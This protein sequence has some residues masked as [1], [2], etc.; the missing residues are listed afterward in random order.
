MQSEIVHN[1]ELHQI[2]N[3]STGQRLRILKSAADTKRSIAS[4]G[5]HLPA[6]FTGTTFPLPPSSAGRISGI[7]GR[8][9]RAYR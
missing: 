3:H 5:S 6:A 8:N 4:N 7:I 1:N 9:D 2:L